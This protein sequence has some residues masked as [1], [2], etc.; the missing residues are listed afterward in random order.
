MAIPLSYN[1]RNLAVRRTTSLMTALSIGLTVAVLLSVMALVSGLRTAFEA[2]GHPLNV[3]VL[4]KGSNSELVSSMTRTTFQ[5]LRSKRGIAR[6]ADGTLLASHELVTTVFLKGPANPNGMN[7]NL[8]GLLPVAFRMR[9]GARLAAGRMFQPGTRELVVGQSVA[10][11]YPMAGLGRQVEFG[12]GMWTV[13]G[14][15]DAG[16][17]AAN[18]E[19][20]ADLNLVAADLYRNEV[21]S[22]ALLRAEDEVA[23]QALINDLANDPRFNVTAEGEREYYL[24]QTSAAAPVQ[25]MGLLVAALM[26]VGSS[27]AAMNTMYTAVAR[28]SAEIGTLRVLGFSQRSILLSFL[29]ES[30]LLSAAGGALGGLAVLPLDNLTTGVGSVVT[31]SEVAFEMHVTWRHLAG[32]VGFAMLLG[33]VGGLLPAR[34]A[35]RREIIEALRAG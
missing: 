23:R 18:S 16:R 30:V 3:L 33:A 13:V 29:V 20:F 2:T 24:A 17:S 22:S 28:R 15:L 27:F 25:F 32:G 8:R 5:D 9:E 7:V 6:D 26:A 34:A 4:R 10:R 14:I 11:R 31:F 35:A 21:P 12:R 19:L 1:L